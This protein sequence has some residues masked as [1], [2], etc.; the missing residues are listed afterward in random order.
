MDRKHPEVECTCSALRMASRKLTQA[1]DTALAREGIR[2]SQYSLLSTLAKWGDYVPT[3][4]ELADR[5]AL[6]RTTL[7]H[8]LGPLARDGFVDIRSDPEDRRSR[9][10]LLTALG[11]QKR[12][13][14]LPLWRAAQDR[15]DEAFGQQRSETL[16]GALLAV[17]RQPGIAAP[18]QSKE[19]DNAG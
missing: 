18:S 9:R 13:T 17:A 11:H 16:R 6:D 12:E 1:Y 7:V 5:L 19:A 4:Q 2:V 8:N 14:C 3:M 10:I 15:F